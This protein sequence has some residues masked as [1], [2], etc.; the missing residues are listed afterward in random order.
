MSV[1]AVWSTKLHAG[2]V[3]GGGTFVGVYTVPSGKVLILRTFTVKNLYAGAQDVYIGLTGVAI[4]HSLKALAL[5]ESRDWDTWHVFDAGD[6]LSV[7]PVTGDVS[8]LLSG[9]LLTEP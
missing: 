7:W 1:P 4:I 9:Q 5:D 3:T 2:N 8:V 6:A